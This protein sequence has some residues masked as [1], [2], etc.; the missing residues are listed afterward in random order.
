MNSALFTQ[1]TP[2]PCEDGGLL[3]AFFGSLVM[4][5]HGDR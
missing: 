5:V 1:M 4:S 2:P 3:N